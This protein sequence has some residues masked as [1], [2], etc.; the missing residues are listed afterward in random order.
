MSP[1][2]KEIYETINFQSKYDNL[3]IKNFNLEKA[4]IFSLGLTLF[5]IFGLIYNQSP[6]LIN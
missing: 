3:N 5:Y 4:D 2:L 1:E 6:K